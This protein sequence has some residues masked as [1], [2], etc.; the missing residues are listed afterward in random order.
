MKIACLGN[1]NNIISP[2]AQYLAELG[3]HVDLF[4]LHE[5][6]HFKPEADYDNVNEIKFNIKELKMDFGK[7]MDLPID[8]LKK[9]LTGY[10]FYIGTDYAP[11]ILARINICIDLFAWAGTDLYEWPFYKSK[12]VIPQLWENERIL[13]SNLQKIGIKNAKAIPMSLNNDYILKIIDKTGFKGDIINP[14]PFLH[15]HNT[16][17]YNLEGLD[18][19]IKLKIDSLRKSSDI[20]LVQQSRQWWD[21]APSHVTK[22]NDVFL[23]GVYEFK[24]SN[25]QVRVG[26]MLFEYGQDVIQTKELLKEL[27]LTE[28]CLWIPLVL[29][30]H[31][32]SIISIADIGV[33]L[34]GSE[35]WYL[36]CSNAEIIAAN[37]I[38]MGY[39]DDDFC[40][41]KNIPLYPMLNANSVEEIVRQLHF[42]N[43]NK[44][45]I[46]EYKSESYEWLINYNEID[47]LT[48]LKARMLDNNIKSL[49]FLD[50]LLL[51]FL[52]AKLFYYKIVNLVVLKTKS[53]LII[54]RVLKWKK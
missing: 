43:N 21:T 24:K 49:F 11:A 28:N 4:L 50:S 40:K 38:Y 51:V 9:E 20:L 10:D 17:K 19:D 36:Y 48:N 14:M 22:G 23:K 52:K 34:F 39:R 25:P 35:S 7:V 12:F 6:E 37:V 41:S 5:F 15:Y 18:L 31:L 47:F 42:Y 13:I 44:P 53:S 45:I 30:K 1:M 33:G 2:T 54:N 32:I 16:K 27:N 29:R 46:E 8:L 26:L 3:H